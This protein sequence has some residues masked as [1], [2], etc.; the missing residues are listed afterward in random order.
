M[1]TVKSMVQARLN[2]AKESKNV[3]KFNNKQ[4]Q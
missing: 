4:C 2:K 3:P 1:L